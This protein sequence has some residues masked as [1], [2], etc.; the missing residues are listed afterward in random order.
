[1]EDWIKDIPLFFGLFGS[2]FAAFFYTEDLF[3]AKG[4][5]WKISSLGQFIYTF[6]NRKWFF[7]KIYNEFISQKVLN[8]GFWHMYLNL[9]RGIL[10]LLGPHGLSAWLSNIAL[11]YNN[12]FLLTDWLFKEWDFFLISFFL[13]ISLTCIFIYL[14]NIFAFLIFFATIL[15]LQLSLKN[16]N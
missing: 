16:V 4:F 10:E 7:D 5:K 8:I 13:I 15:F 1:L 14:N 9:D 11:S 6:L 3:F 2:V 12:Q